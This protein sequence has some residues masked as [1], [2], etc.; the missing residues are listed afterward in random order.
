MLEKLPPDP[1]LSDLQLF[2][3]SQ[4]WSKKRDTWRAA[5][6][7]YEDFMKFF[8]PDRK[9][10][11]IFRADVA[12]YRTWSSKKGRGSST[13]SRACEYGVRMYK[14]LNELELVEKD[15]NPFVGMAPRR[16]RIGK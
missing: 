2:W 11:D 7:A 9:P 12:E 8:G 14:L 13:I 3:E 6:S 16:I 15:F 4:Y 1:S 5:A 10:R